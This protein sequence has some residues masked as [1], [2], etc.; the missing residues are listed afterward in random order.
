MCW[1][2][3]GGS[4]FA[5][6]WTLSSSSDEGVRGV[7]E[8]PTTRRDSSRRDLPGVLRLSSNVSGAEEEGFSARDIV[9]VW[10]MMEV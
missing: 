8:E 10:D 2:L 1:T 7:E 6:R 3:S 4:T 9:S 5:S